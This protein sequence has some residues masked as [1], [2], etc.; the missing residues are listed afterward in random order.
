[1][2]KGRMEEQKE[3]DVKTP[4]NP[5]AV[6]ETKDAAALAGVSESTVSKACRRGDV[7]AKKRGFGLTGDWSIPGA[8]VQRLREA[9][10]PACA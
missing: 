8:E 1:M 9:Y 4:I 10:A 2:R 6:Y 3:L 7:K 5:E